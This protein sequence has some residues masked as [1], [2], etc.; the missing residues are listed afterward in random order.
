MPKSG[1]QGGAKG[2]S[3]L[4]QTGGKQGLAIF[5]DITVCITSLQSKPLPHCPPGSHG[6][7]C[8]Q[9][10][11]AFGNR[12]VSHGVQAGSGRDGQRWFGQEVGSSGKPPPKKQKH[13][14]DAVKT[15]YC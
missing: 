7:M 10:G 4:L 6:L 15:E 11:S 3:L 13:L 12:L 5:C 1:Q 2:G 9:I 14:H 8:Q